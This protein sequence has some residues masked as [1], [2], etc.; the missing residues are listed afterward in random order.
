MCVCMIPISHEF[1]GNNKGMMMIFCLL[2]I[3]YSDV[4]QRN[5][6]DY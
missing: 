2:E 1:L 5:S 6:F 4:P 3:L